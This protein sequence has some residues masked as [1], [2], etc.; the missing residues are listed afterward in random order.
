[1]LRLHLPA[2]PA[3]LAALVL[4]LTLPAAPAQAQ[5]DT[6]QFHMAQANSYYR[7]RLLPKALAELEAVVADEEGKKSLKA[8]QLIVD[9]S[10]KLKQ[11][12]KLIWALENARELASGQQAAQMQAQLY[13]LKRVYGRVMFEAAGGSGK[14]PEKGIVLKLKGDLDDPEAK[15][16]YEKGRLQFSQDGYSVGSI[17]LPAGD[18][19][20]DGAPL[21][22]IAGK[23]TLV[24]VAPT[25]DVRFAIEVAGVGGVRVGQAGTG[26]GPALGGLDLGFGPHIQFATGNSLIIHVGP[27]LLLSGQGTQN[28]RQDD[29]LN[30]STAQLSLGG[31]FM[32][33][34]EFKVGTIDLSPRVGFAMH[35]LASGMYFR[36]KVVSTPEGSDVPSTVLEG[37]FI[38]PAIAYGPRLGF[39]ALVT[40]ALNERG[41]RVPRVFVGLQGGPIWAKPLWGDVGEAGSLVAVSGTM[42]RDPNDANTVVDTLREGPFS[43]ESIVGGD[44][45]GKAKIYAD[46]HVIVGFQI[47]L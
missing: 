9:I 31:T 25:T 17:Y 1:M 44:E 34:L 29:Y 47:R 5:Q 36:G 46:I 2:L 19:D 27:I 7:N 10:G 16:Y 35:Y 13:R 21:K 43:V 22:I 8:W 37:E 40:P 11:L 42:V 24:E 14:L 3:V 6:W 39:Q 15:A 38:V 32:V 20:L 26:V 4:G 12:D 18:Y 28:V 23:D 30:H 45:V 33:G 41:K